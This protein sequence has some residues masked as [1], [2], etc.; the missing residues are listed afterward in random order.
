MEKQGSI[1]EDLCREVL[2]LRKLTD[3]LREH[4]DQFATRPEELEKLVQRTERR[5]PET[6]LALVR[7]CHY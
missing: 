1:S 6:A 4:A 3:R 5:S 7:R 2:E